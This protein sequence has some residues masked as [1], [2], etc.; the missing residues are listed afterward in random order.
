MVSFCNA[1]ETHK[2]L[3]TS[4]IFDDD[5]ALAKFRSV[6][7]TQAA[8]TRE[9]GEICD[10]TMACWRCCQCA[11][12]ANETGRKCERG[13][14]SGFSIA[15]HQRVRKILE[16]AK[17]LPITARSSSFW[18][19][20]SLSSILPKEFVSLCC[21]GQLQRCVIR[22]HT[23]VSICLLALLSSHPIPYNETQK[24]TRFISL[25][26]LHSVFYLFIILYPASS[27]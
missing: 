16:D 11:E 23:M 12:F 3:V 13:K 27:V 7:C 25:R 1:C 18:P 15:S 8:R 20:F 5:S 22:R 9:D 21:V 24:C 4:R 6:S 17:V 19:P 2:L 14:R 26:V 10:A